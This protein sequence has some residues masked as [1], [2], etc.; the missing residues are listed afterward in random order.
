MWVTYNGYLLGRSPKPSFVSRVSYRA[1]SPHLLKI[2]RMKWQILKFC[3]VDHLWVGNKDTG[4]YKI[5][6][7][8]LQFTQEGMDG[9]G[10]GG[11]DLL[12][13]RKQWACG[14][15]RALHVTAFSLR[16]AIWPKSWLL[17]QGI[18]CPF[19]SIFLH[20]ILAKENQ[21]YTSHHE[22]H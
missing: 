8:I 6:K 2:S 13:S 5:R 22:N 15:R 7:W 3:V 10:G 9:G 17:A 20:T 16:S 14:S 11:V 21:H 1:R 19:S 12:L 18:P 4:H